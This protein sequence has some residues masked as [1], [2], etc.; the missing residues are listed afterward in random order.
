MNNASRFDVRRRR[1]TGVLLWVIASACSSL[2]DVSAPDVVQLDALGNAAGAEALRVGSLGGFALVFAGSEQGQIT[3]SGAMADEF[4]NATSGFVD[5]AP[6]DIRIMPEPSRSYPYPA[7]QRSRLDARRAI[8][9]LQQHAPAGRAKIGEQFAIVAY[10]EL[11]LAENMCSGI[12]LGEIV[13]GNPVYGQPLSTEELY[14]RA[15]ADFDSGAVY[16]ANDARI[17]DLARVGRGRTQLGR[18]QFADAAASVAAVPTAYEYTTQY[19]PAQPNGVYLIINTEK[20]LTVADLEGGN[21]LDFRSAQDPRVPT[22]FVDKGSDGFTDV[23]TFT[24]YASVSSPVVL[25]SGV[26]ARLI[27]AE[28]LLRTGDAGGALQRL[29]ALR[30]RMTGLAPLTLQPTT[31]AQV[32][33][34]FRERAFWLFATGHRHGD[35]RR[36]VRQYGRPSTSV[37]PTGAYKNGLTYGDDVT[38]TPDVAQA[39][40]PNFTKCTS[41]GA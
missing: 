27:E 2:T 12:P 41:R 35:L 37:F 13:N 38:F 9:A 5:L 40:N 17:R 39:S 29:N 14:L 7:M 8:A 25:A 21:G 3:T 33:Q 6:A 32:D 1:R 23:Y 19:S 16:A 18:A 4:F 34:L 31:A 22:A 26:E 36:L 30:A 11:F 10:T 24:Q 28:A 20:W 15:L